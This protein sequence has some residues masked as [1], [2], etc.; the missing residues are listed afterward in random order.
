[1]PRKIFRAGSSGGIPGT[2]YEPTPREKLEHQLQIAHKQHRRKLATRLEQEIQKE[3]L[4]EKDSV[5]RILKRS[6]PTPPLPSPAEIKREI[7]RH[8][9]EATRLE[10]QRAFFVTRIKE[11]YETKQP[12]RGPWIR[13]RQELFR[14]ARWIGIHGKKPFILLDAEQLEIVKRR[15]HRFPDRQV[16][17]ELCISP[18]TYY[19]RVREIGAKLGMPLPPHR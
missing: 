3:S 7:K 14:M 16:A 9:L 18:S 4:R 11:A 5:A 13:V 8:K 1:M 10:R 17:E 12:L 15:Y 19:R 6:H 2:A